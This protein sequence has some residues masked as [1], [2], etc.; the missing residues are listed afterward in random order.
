MNMSR[1]L[2]LAIGLGC[3]GVLQE[4]VSAPAPEVR[5]VAEKQSVVKAA[6]DLLHKFWPSLQKDRASYGLTAADGLDTLSFG[7]PVELRGVRDDS[8]RAYIPGGAASVAKLSEPTHQWYVPLVAQGAYRAFIE[9]QDLG[10]GQWQGSGI[11]WVPL[12]Q[13]W[14]AIARRWPAVEGSGP[15]LLIFFSQPG[16]YVAV[17]SVRPENLTPLSSLKLNPD[18]TLPPSFKLEPAAGIIERLKAA[19]AAQPPM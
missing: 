2:A 11:G 5:L 18:G 3:F 10:Q 19:A 17:P 8:L 12:A 1:C 4:A 6:Q 7:D 13:K 9:V 14:Q 15:V 16:Y